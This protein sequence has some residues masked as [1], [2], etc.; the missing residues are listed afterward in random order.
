MTKKQSVRDKVAWML[1]EHGW[2][3]EACKCG[4]D[5]DDIDHVDH[6]AAELDRAGLIV[7]E[8]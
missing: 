2:E 8:R 7:R 6:Q 1:Y 3:N 5:E 4:W